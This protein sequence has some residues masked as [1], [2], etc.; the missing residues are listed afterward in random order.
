MTSDTARLRLSLVGVVVVS[1]FAAM[2]AR[3]WYLQVMDAE[4]L[5]TLATRNQ[6]R[7]VYEPAPRGT[8]LPATPA[9]AR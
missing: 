6:A 9:M 3:L 1:L 2:F 5:Q 4:E 7:V 8:H